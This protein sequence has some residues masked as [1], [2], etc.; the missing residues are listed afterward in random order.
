MK[1]IIDSDPGIDDAIAIM[2][3]YLNKL[4][5]VGFTVTCGNVTLKNA[6]R[7]LKTIED[8]LESDIKIY[9]GEQYIEGGEENIACFAHGKYGLG[10][11]VYPNSRREVEDKKADDFL[12][13]ASKEYKDNLTI[14]CLGSLTNVA[15][16]IKKD[17]DFASRVSQIF[18]MGASYD[19]TRVEDP[20]IEFNIKTNPMA[21]KIVFEA[22]FKDIRVIT[23]EA[24]ILTI[25]PSEYINTLKDSTSLVSNFV[26]QIS[27]KYLEFNLEDYNIDGLT[28]PDPLTVAAVINPEVAKYVKC[29]VNII[30]DGERKGE[31]VI[32]LNEGNINIISGVNLRLF[33]ELFK[34]TFN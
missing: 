17:P 16:A 1:Y 14:I 11:A 30:T 9:V 21:A 33:S 25:I 18:I 6:V 26:Y 12:I 28:M 15:N 34:E 31:T 23:H 19:P 7:N 22:D 2:M 10:N 32:K 29:N 24:A 3:A 4:D 8:F 13:E 27:E 5:I 20:Y